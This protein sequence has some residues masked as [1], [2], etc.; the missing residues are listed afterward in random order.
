MTERRVSGSRIGVLADEPQ[1]LDDLV[2]DAAWRGPR[3][4]RRLGP[5]DQA[6]RDRR[7]DVRDRVDQDRERRTDQLD[8]AAGEA[9][10]A[11]LGQRRAGASLLLPSTTRSTPMSDGTY[12][13]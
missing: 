1:A 8:E 12:A 7:D 13:G 11:D 5:P 9:G 6:E 4:A 3:R 2:P 10:A